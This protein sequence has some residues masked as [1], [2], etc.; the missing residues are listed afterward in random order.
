MAASTPLDQVD[1]C[2]VDTETTGGSAQL[3]RVIEVA[4]YHVHDGIILGHFQTLINPGRPIPFWITGLTGIDDTMVRNAPSFCDIAAPLKT[5]LS[6]GI[7]VAH[8]ALFDFRFIK[9][10]FSRAGAE[11]E[12]PRLCTVKLARRLYPELP[13]RSLDALCDHFLI[14]IADRHRAFG[15]AEATVYVL[16]ELLRKAK[17][18]LGVITWEALD[19]LQTAK[20]K[21]KPASRVR[22]KECVLPGSVA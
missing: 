22:R 7:F 21:E 1:F 19:G 13:S 2:V 16:K 12:R 18:D 17:R 14:D 9:E 3:N 5:F 20:K 11:F 8:N 6:K 10:E 15:D 4:A